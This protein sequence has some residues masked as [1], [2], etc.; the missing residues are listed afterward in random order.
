MGQQ[1]IYDFLKKH[2]KRAPNKWYTSKELSQRLGISI[3][4]ITMSLKKLRESGSIKFKTTKRNMFLY[5]FK[6]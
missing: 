1:D 6:K 4:S 2:H 3:G 5:Q